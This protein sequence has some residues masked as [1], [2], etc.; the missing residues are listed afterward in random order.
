MTVIPFLIDCAN[1]TIVE[2][3]EEFESSG[4]L[5]GDVIL[6][7]NLDRS[8]VETDK[9]IEKQSSNASYDLR[10]GGEYR[11]HREMGKTDLLD[12]G[13]LYLPPGAAVIIETYEEVQFP[14]SRFGHIVP[15]VKLLMEGI[16]NTSSK[17]DPG[18]DGR[19]L[20]T[21]FN[22]GTKKIVTSQ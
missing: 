1:R 3:R 8:Q 13:I 4:G 11:D 12:D 5:E 10:V 16:S 9:V 19:L 15:K 14:R 18:F 20:I 21:V 6:I 2:T 17:V 22:L 7:K